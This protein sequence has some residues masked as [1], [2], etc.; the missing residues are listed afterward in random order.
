MK[1]NVCV[2]ITLVVITVKSALRVSTV[3]LWRAPKTTVHL[4][5]VQITDL[6]SYCPT[7]RSLVSSVR[8]AMQVTNHNIF[9]VLGFR[10]NINRINSNLLWETFGNHNVVK[11]TG[12]TYVWTASLV[13]RRV[14]SGQL[15]CAANVTVMEM[16]IRMLS[17]TVIQRP[18]L[19]WS[20]STILTDLVA[21]DAY[22]D[23][24]EM[25]SLCQKWV[26]RYVNVIKYYHVL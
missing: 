17:E 6:V 22:L 5:R 12:V 23:S 16:S 18:V 26:K 7:S 13:I 25:L 20:V 24:M 10:W 2:S 3:T 8:S 1:A 9:S 19:A 15:V 4:V 14:A 11:A 21:I